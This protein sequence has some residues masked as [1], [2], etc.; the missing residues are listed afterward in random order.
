MMKRILCLVL[1]LGMVLGMLSGCR[2]DSEEAYVPTGDAI[3]M[4]G[5]EEHKKVQSDETQELSLAYYPAQTLN[6]YNCTDYTNRAM[7]P[8]L[9]QSLFTLNRDYEA[10]PQLCESYTVSEDLRLYDITLNPRATFSDGTSVTAE[11]VQASFWVAQ[12]SAYYSGRFMH[13]S[14]MGVSDRGTVLV[15]L[16]QPC[17]NLPLLL[18]F[19]IVKASTVW[20][21][22]PMGSGPYIFSGSTGNWFLS[23]RSTW[24]CQSDDLLITAGRIPLLEV[25]TPT[26]VRDHFEFGDVGI[27]CTDPGS[28]Y[29]VEYRCDYELW[30]CETG[31]FLFIGFNRNSSF[32]QNDV[33]R[34]AV[35]RG[36]D[37]ALLVDKYYQGFA[38]VAELPAS[39]NSPFYSRTLAQ[40]YSYDE[41]EFMSLMSTAGA[42]GTSIRLLVNSD[43]SLR[44]KVAQEI[45]R[46]LNACGLIVTI[47]A[48]DA[49]A[50]YDRL[51]TFDYDLYLGQTKL[52]PNMDMSPFFSES[53]SLNICGMLGINEYNLCLNALENEG[54]YYPLYQTIM[55]NALICPLLFR[56]YAVYASRGLLTDLAPARDNLFSYTIE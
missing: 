33:A 47:D 5:E 26:E 36:I 10:I 55:D 40:N 37:R 14:N 48:V 17:S 13:V 28:D 29:Y 52:S 21:S 45:G 8:L 35:L 50:Y 15:Y 16:N 3:L 51:L 20:D 25:S 39:S 27:V 11:D 56:S 46:M 30:D 43:D 24:W 38:T 49:D 9:Y 4:E 31:I 41:A 6:P 34:Q 44:V 23:R 12:E 1:C 42:A 53:G 7:F 2:A 19:P 32:F 22:E 54:N 18:D